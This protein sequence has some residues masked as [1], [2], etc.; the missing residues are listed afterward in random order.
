MP[1]DQ[2]AATEVL[3]RVLDCPGISCQEAAIADVVKEVLLEAGV[4]PKAI[5][6]DSAHRKTPKPG[7]VGNLIVKLPGRGAGKGA[8]RVML[9]AHLDTVPICD[10]CEPV[11]KG[12]KI[13]SKN[14]AT[15]LGGDDRA[16]VA[17]VLVAAIDALNSDGDHPPLTLCFFVQEEIGLQG[18]RNM[19]VSKIGR[20]AMAFNFDGGNPFKLTIGAT[21]GERMH[22]R[23][24]GIPAHAGL[25]PEEGASAIEAAGIA[26]A[27][28]N[29][30][31]WLGDVA[32][33][34]NRGTS[35]IG[36]IHGGVATNVV[37][38]FAELTAEARSHN[39]PFRNKIAQAIETAFKKA[40]KR[41]K[42][43]SGVPVKAEVERRVDYE[44]FRL[45]ENCEV[46]QRAHRAVSELGK[47]PELT[48]SNGGVDANWIVKHGIP[49]VTLG[50]G[51]RNVHTKEE[52]LD[53]S[54]Y[55]AACQIARS[56][57]THES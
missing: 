27:D 10:G 30:A 11:K 45:D 18:S 34:R 16:G 3:L 4:E 20:P 22:V 21:G 51:Q 31:G 14:P 40:A 55:Y 17:T 42:T 12:S 53:L 13:I 57:I 38:E 35:N 56:V 52:W 6:H 37:A 39:G 28:L 1:I 9:S 47:K 44:S 41:I 54:D 2:R 50:C 5:T 8:P 24:T 36:S 29:A 49:T 46:V 33:G 7:Q 48:V 32:K 43:N 26:I 25:A 15:G 23:L 19:T